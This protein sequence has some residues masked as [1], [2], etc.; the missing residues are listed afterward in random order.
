VALKSLQQRTAQNGVSYLFREGEGTS[1]VLLHGI[2]SNGQS[3]LPLIEA[4]H[5]QGAVVAWDAPGYGASTP[6]ARD[7]PLAA[8]YAGALE[9][10]LEELRVERTILAGHSL[11]TLM[12]ASY[13]RNYGARLKGL[14]L[15]SP[16]LGHG[17]PRGGPMPEAAKARLDAFE[18]LGAAGFAEQRALQLIHDPAKKP[19]LVA[20]LART[21]ATLRPQGYGQAVRMLSS[22]RL[23]DDVTLMDVPCLVICG[24]EDA[25][26]PPSMA[27]RVEAACRGRAVGDAT[28]LALVPQAG[29]M[30]YLE[31]AD[32]VLRELRDFEA[33]IEAG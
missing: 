14:V 31:A 12:A 8:D 9:A 18:R 27:R 16:S 11:G 22:G 6:L 25:I 24:S 29:H 1:L 20:E 28:R 30:V 4:L 15:M 33:I 10:L 13:A 3:F 21:L 23:L 17:A 2:G 5:G 19:G 26:T 32:A 7:W